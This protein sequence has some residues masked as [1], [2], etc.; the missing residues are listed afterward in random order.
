M[1]V[2]L[3]CIGRLE[4][5]YA[6]EFVEFYKAIG[7]DKIF[8]Y[9][10]NYGNEEH[11]EDVLQGY[12]V[13][14]FVEV[15][16]YRDIHRCQLTAY[17]DCYN[18]YGREYDWI[19][20]FDFDEFIY[21]E[22]NL[23][24]KELLSSSIYDDY[25]V[26]H[27][28]WLC[29]G[30]NNLV[31]HEDRDVVSRFKTP[32]FPLYFKKRLKTPENAH[33]KSIIRGGLNEVLWNET[34]HTPSNDLRCCD[35]MGR[36]CKCS[37]PFVYPLVYSNVCLRHYMTKTI[38]E[39]YETKVMRGFAD[40]NKDFFK[41]YNWVDEF[42][43]VNEKTNGKCSY[44]NKIGANILDIFIGTYKTFN[45]TVNN[46]SYKVI[47]GNHDVFEYGNLKYFE[48]IDESSKLDDRFYSEI[49]MLRNLP[50]DY[51]LPKY[52]GFCHYRKY[53]DFMDDIPN[54]DE[55]FDKYDAVLANEVEFTVSVREQ[56]AKYHNIEDLEIVERIIKEKFSEYCD[57]F[58]KLMDGNKLFP[59][60]MFIM[61]REDF[62]EYIKFIG[63]VLDEY[64]NVVGDD[65]E[66][67][68]IE[69]KEKYLKKFS[70]NDTYEYQYRIG[71]Y[72]AERLTNVYVL[73]HF[74]N[75]M[76]FGVKITEEKYI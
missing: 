56:Y 18:R 63:D 12:I 23:G 3:C 19:C 8:I 32:I 1:E 55:I 58:D 28:N 22:H 52:V 75:I 37:S 73:K 4:N 42:F 50:K 72:L 15:I 6:V 10:N 40:G 68:L 57:A 65:I 21:I 14:G 61:K 9:D 46:F 67:R 2:A 26:I 7:I 71:G 74:K 16:N 24:I 62:K 69:N 45:P 41:V 53:F 51:E 60:N 59:Y 34:P 49:Y 29:Y 5:R 66:K 47:Y 39:Y 43:K 30:D 44:I 17:Q 36:S 64:I 31:R 35:A 25:D 33:I 11:F 27:I 76:T 13:S 20:F 48:C 70:P 38:E 54:M